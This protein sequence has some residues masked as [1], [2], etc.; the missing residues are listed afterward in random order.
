MPAR[1]TPAR[2]A[3]N[4]HGIPFSNEFDDAYHS[5]DGGIGQAEHVFLNGNDLPAR[6]QGR[7]MFTIVETG[8]GQGLNFLV[9]WAAWRADPA[10]GR[11]LHFASV[12]RHPFG[13]DDLAALLARL[14]QFGELAAQLVERW[15]DL[16][17]GFH[18]LALD[19]GR[20]TLTLLF[21]DALDVLPELDA[22]ADAIYLDGFSPAKNPELWSPEVF[23]QLWRLSHPGTTLATYTAAGT[24]RRSLNECG[25]AVERAKGYGSKWHMLR[26]GVARAPRQARSA[27]TARH[28][29]IVGAGLAGCAT[30][31]RLAARGW[32][33]DL[34]DSAPAPATQSSGNPAGLMHAYV[35]QDDNLLSRLSRAGNAAT[36]AKL[37]ELAGAGLTVPHGVDGILQVARDDAQ[38]ALQRKI[39]EAGTCHGLQFW[40]ADDA[41]SRLGLRP[42]RGGWWFERGAWINPPAYCAALLAR[43]ADRIRFRPDTP[44]VRLARD[45][46]TQQWQA[47]DAQ[48]R[49]VGTA[50]VVILANASAAR[51]LA[52]G[53]ELPLW[54][55]ARVASRL[56]ADALPL[57]AAGIAGAGYVTGAHAGER[58][59]GAAAYGGDLAA[60]G[61]DNR[62]ALMALLPDAG[63][64]DDIALTHRLCQRPASPD[65]LPL[66]GA[67]PERWHAGYPRC[68]QPQQ[69]PRQ[70]GLYGVLGFGARGL[71]WA[72]LMGELLASQLDGEPLPL[73]KSLVRAVDPARFLLRALRR[74]EAYQPP[75]SGSDD[76]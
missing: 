46:A 24:V 53:S 4:E 17:P 69:I 9:T 25:F 3:F 71:S 18:R 63:L 42:A 16:T 72:T 44:I 45:E 70:P 5:P 50:P 76:D 10:A 20:I 61:D 64:A 30:A 68:H 15:P 36:L 65:R 12:E 47:F 66:V 7:D 33:I 1:I 62:K 39:A 8:F 37:A 6:W 43:H 31:E 59:I 58:V 67:L 11:R 48:D 40:S 34:V 22:C 51:A 26:G 74:G 54:S 75:L 13:R 41:R 60:A 56:A 32:C 23:R 14:P 73:E 55:V 57:P 21:G 29:L 38:E 2:L 28:A 35:S 52:Q 19:E 27:S 49:L